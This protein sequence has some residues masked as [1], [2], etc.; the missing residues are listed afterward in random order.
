MRRGRAT[1]ALALAS[2]ALL[3]RLVAADSWPGA[4]ITE[5][6]SAN[7]AW[8][9]R[10]TPGTSI[11][12]TVG[13]AGS[14]TGAF[15]TA[16]WF[17]RQADGGY[18]VAAR[19]TL[20]NPVA[21]IEARVTNRGYLV[22]LDN[23]HNVGYGIAVAS[24]RPDG[25]R[26]VGLTLADVYSKTEIAAFP[27]TVSSIWWRSETVYTRDDQRSIYVGGKVPGHELILEP[28]T[29]RWQVCQPRPDGHHCRTAN[30]ARTWASFREP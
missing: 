2:C 6:F 1:I 18:R 12:D 9:V 7:R 14:R 23:W 22:T 11:G 21:P 3:T 30:E 8:F 15:A 24:Y 16:E 4:V 26:V 29:G 28:E 5:T 17:E 13:F 25:T 10:V 19:A 27:H 20:A